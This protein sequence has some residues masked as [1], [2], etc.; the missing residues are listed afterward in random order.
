MAKTG[1]D[2]QRL[3]RA[4]E[5]ARA[6]GQPIQIESPKRVRDKITGKL[7]EH[8]VVL[9]I[10]HAHHT[11]VVAL[12]CRDRSRPI[13]VEAVEAF[14]SKCA[15]T[16]VHS[17]VMVSSKGFTRT[18]IKKAAVY[19]I[20]CLSLD[21]ADGFNWCQ[22][23]SVTVLRKVI[24]KAYFHVEFSKGTE[25]EHPVVLYDENGAVIDKDR[26]RPIAQENINAQCALHGG[27]T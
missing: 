19:N 21:Q 11:M 5:S 24:T 26:V 3:I 9:T 15:D 17:G 18:A 10:T 4:I 13:G 23:T 16:G 25:L 6:A 7:R 2:L 8:D 1:R 27:G 20:S 12:E 22:P 14:R